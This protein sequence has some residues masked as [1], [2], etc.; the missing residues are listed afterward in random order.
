MPRAKTKSSGF[1]AARAV[2][3]RRYNTG[4]KLLYGELEKLIEASESI[5]EVQRILSRVPESAQF[6]GTAWELSERMIQSL[7]GGQK[8]AWNELLSLSKAGRSITRAVRTERPSALGPV[9]SELITENA[10]LN[11]TVPRDLAR[12]FSQMAAQA[13]SSGKTSEDILE[14]IKREAENLQGWEAQRIARTET[15]KASTMLIQARAETLDLGFYIWRCVKDGRTRPAHRYMDGVICRWSDPPNPERLSKAKQYGPYHPGCI[16]N[17]RCTPEVIVSL[18]EIAFPAKV[19]VN[20]RIVT[21][22]S[23]RAFRKRFELG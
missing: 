22:R 6:T 20:G 4:L 17:C 2:S 14:D 10:D 12:R 7:S 15:S 19:H 1:I 16:F 11:K 3:E 23:L 18:D 21:V 8:R 5:P 13:A 9:V